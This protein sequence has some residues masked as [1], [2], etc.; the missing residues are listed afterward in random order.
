MNRDLPEAGLDALA[1]AIACKDE[2]GWR[3]QSRKI[4]VLMTDDSY[5]AAGDGRSAGV[6]KPYD[7]KCY[8]KNNVYENELVM[9]YPSVSMINKLARDNHVIV[10]FAV[11]SDV[12][13]KLVKRIVGS[14]MITLS[15][16]KTDEIV[17]KL[18]EIYEVIYFHCLC[19]P[20][21]SK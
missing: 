14:K 16:T 21:M 5:H 19:L 18:K 12:Y 6:F 1:Q 9:D 20:F 11:S 7:G 10:I 8:T 13:T 2:I 4:L 3:N 15:D 17:T